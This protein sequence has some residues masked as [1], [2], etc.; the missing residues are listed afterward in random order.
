MQLREGTFRTKL[1]VQHPC[2]ALVSGLL[3]T[4]PKSCMNGAVQYAAFEPISLSA[5]AFVSL[6][7]HFTTG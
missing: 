2:I 4:Y 5:V 1:M 3:G 6:A 7:W